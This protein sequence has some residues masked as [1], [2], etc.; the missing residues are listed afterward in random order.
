[1]LS[2]FNCNRRLWVVAGIAAITGCLGIPV[3][4]L[5]QTYPN[6]PLTLITP[7]AAGGPVDVTA[8]LVASEISVILKQ[9]V[10]VDNRPGAS[11]KIGIQ[12]L[13]RA[14]RDGYTFAAASGAS[15]TI[16]PLL[17]RTLGYD[18]LKDFTLLSYA[19]EI[20]TM[21]VVNPSVP[22]RSLGEL[23]AYAKANP[24]K[25][26]YG[27]GGTGTSLHFSTAALLSML[28]ITALHVPYKSSGPA[29]LGLLN[30]AISIL[31][32]DIGTAKSHVSSGKLLALAISGSKR[33]EEF[34]NVPIFSEMGIPE[35]KGYDGYKQWVGF[36]A[37]AGIPQE[38]ATML[39][40]ALDQALRAPK[41]KEVFGTMGFPIISSTPQQFADQLRGELEYNQKM[42]DS[43]VV[44]LNDPK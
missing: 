9:R 32:P 2:A 25:L 10:V 8:R 28:G 6:R 4:A 14:P 41:V 34:P 42:M 1:M 19:I 23:V 18:P 33:S 36:I 16:N 43:G 12:A 24:E 38:A 7:T 27:S 13:L 39:Q 44:N 15:L 5:A 11:Q 20:P 30:G 37:A 3:F 22:A 40:G 31:M 29:L 17:D 35:L 21:L 26:S